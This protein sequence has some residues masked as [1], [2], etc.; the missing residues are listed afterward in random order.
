MEGLLFRHAVGTNAMFL[1]MKGI[2]EGQI[3]S[4]SHFL[5]GL[6]ERLRRESR[7]HSPPNL[8]SQGRC[9]S[10]RLRTVRG[11]SWEHHTG[12]WSS[13]QHRSLSRER[14]STVLSSYWLGLDLHQQLRS[15][16]RYITLSSLWVVQSQIE[17]NVR[18]FLLT[19][20][21]EAVS[22]ERC[23]LLNWFNMFNISIQNADI[24]R[25]MR[26]PTSWE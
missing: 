1:R 12:P 13:D 19:F 6:H 17:F 11:C 10:G 22:L 26:L 5:S 4:P 2:S 25:V 15:G 9:C 21:I 16:R 24:L 20:E 3:P 23:L 7:L 18:N 8:S 14:T